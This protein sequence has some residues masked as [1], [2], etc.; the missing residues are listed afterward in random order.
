MKEFA[1]RDVRG[2]IIA[3]ITTGGAASYKNTYDEYGN[4]GAGNAGRFRFTGQMWL[5]AY[6]AYNFKARAYRPQLGRF[7][8]TDPIG[9]GDGLN[10]YAYVGGDPVNFR[11]PTGLT[12]EPGDS[13]NADDEQFTDEIVVTSR[14]RRPFQGPPPGPVFFGGGRPGSR[15]TAGGV[16]GSK[17]GDNNNENDNEMLD[18][19]CN[20]TLVNIGNEIVGLADTT[21][22][23]S[24]GALGTGAVVAGG[25]ILMRDPK[26]ARSGAAMMET[27][28]I[29]GI[30]S[31]VLQLAGGVIQSAGGAQ[32]DNAQHAVLQ[33]ASGVAVGRLFNRV[34]PGH[35]TVSQRRHDATQ[36]TL[37]LFTGATIDFVQQLPDIGPEKARC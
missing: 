6:D 25:G 11:D 34:P 7:L 13:D 32:N 29:F 17:N 35:R 8:Q 27:G 21:G 16:G 31:A 22:T 37:G 28:G 20:Q 5:G 26:I 30:G 24:I 9:Y 4:Q 19:E 33:I 3:A 36:G 23:V 1:M 12:G 18:D 14:R 15:N 2:S 10:L